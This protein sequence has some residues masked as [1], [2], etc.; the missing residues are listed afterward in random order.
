MTVCHLQTAQTDDH[1]QFVFTFQF[2]N[3]PR[4]YMYRGFKNNN[5]NNNIRKSL[6]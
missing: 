2:F 3:L 6:S 1:T 5:N 4:D